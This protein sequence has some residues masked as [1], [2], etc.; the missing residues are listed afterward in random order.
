[1][2]NP[3]SFNKWVS[4]FESPHSHKT[5]CLGPAIEIASSDLSTPAANHF[6]KIEQNVLQTMTSLALPAS[7]STNTNL[8]AIRSNISPSLSSSTL[9]DETLS[10]SQTHSNNNLATLSHLSPKDAIPSMPSQVDTKLPEKHH[11]RKSQKLQD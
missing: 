10:A 6:V 2:Q 11:C 7:T 9:L 8:A 4:I 3:P 1:M 5:I